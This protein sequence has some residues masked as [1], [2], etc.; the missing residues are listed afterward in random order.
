M[1]SISTSLFTI[2]GTDT[3]LKACLSLICLILL[4]AFGENWVIY[5]AVVVLVTLDTITGYL[6]A[7]KEHKVSSNA[8]FKGWSKILV[9]IM[10]I[11]AFHQLVRIEPSL[12]IL[13]GYIAL[14]LAAN[15]TISIVENAN[16][17]G[18]KLPSFLVK[19]L[20]KYRDGIKK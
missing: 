4:T 18:I 13:D 14:W 10:L 12:T 2:F 7:R 17:M 8:F 3:A 11:I 15:E 19:G 6:A 5:L 9:F 20:E 1:D 16:R